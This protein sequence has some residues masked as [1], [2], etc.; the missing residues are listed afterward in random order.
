A[1]ANSF[2]TLL[3]GLIFVSFFNLGAWGA[4]YPY[5]SELFPTQY[6]GTCFG[7]AEGVGKTTA[8]L[9]PV[10]FGALLESTGGI[11]APLTVIAVVML[12]GGLFL[13]GVG[14]ETKGEAFT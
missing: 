12:L 14:P 3:L 13:A 1:T 2:A 9:G 8:I 7:M 11:I 4:V 6:R 10:V 5:T